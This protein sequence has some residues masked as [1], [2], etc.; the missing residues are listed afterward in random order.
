MKRVKK[1]PTNN[2]WIAHLKK[3]QRANPDLDWCTITQLGKQTYTKV[4]PKRR[5]LT[6]SSVKPKVKFAKRKQVRVRGA[7]GRF[8]AKPKDVLKLSKSQA[9][10]A[11]L[12]RV[13]GSKKRGGIKSKAIPT[14]ITF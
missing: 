8:V 11:Q 4:K 10:M 3:V 6:P 13:Q 2:R 9:K 7:K 5:T 1:A 14:R 12:K